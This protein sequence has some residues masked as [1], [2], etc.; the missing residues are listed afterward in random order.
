MEDNVEKMNLAF[1][2][3][4][5]SFKSENLKDSQRWTLQNQVKVKMCSLVKQ[6]DL[7]CKTKCGTLGLWESRPNLLGTNRKAK[8][9]INRWNVGTA[10]LC[11]AHPRHFY[12]PKDGRQ[13]SAM[14][15]TTRDCV[16]L[17]LMKLTDFSQIMN[18]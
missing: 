4:F 5:E 3:I 12:L 9:P 17:Q 15:L 11:M 6:R 16:W 10:K 8:R 2:Q 7:L 18:I 1:K 14:M 13:C